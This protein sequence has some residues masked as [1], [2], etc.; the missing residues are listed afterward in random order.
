MLR[1]FL[2]AVCVI[3]VQLRRSAGVFSRLYAE[4]FRAMTEPFT[5]E[6][7]QYIYKLF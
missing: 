1:K 6:R 7:P 5:R 2:Y 3:E 4:R